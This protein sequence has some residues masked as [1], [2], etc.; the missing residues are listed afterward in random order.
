MFY[1]GPLLPTGFWLVDSL[2]YMVGYVMMV[3]VKRSIYSER[4]F[5]SHSS[6]RGVYS[7]RNL[8]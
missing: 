1:Q 3:L 4:I 8:R 6:L 5:H 2:I 7:G